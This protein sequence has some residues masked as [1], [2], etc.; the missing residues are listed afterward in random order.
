M[1]EAP[2]MTKD[3]IMRTALRDAETETLENLEAAGAMYDQLLSSYRPVR[4]DM[5]QDDA[6]GTP[7]PNGMLRWFGY[8][9]DQVE[10]PDDPVLKHD[11]TPQWIGTLPGFTCK[12]GISDARVTIETDGFRTNE[13]YSDEHEL[14]VIPERYRI[15]V[16]AHGFDRAQ[17]TVCPDWHEVQQTCRRIE[18]QLDESHD[19]RHQECQDEEG[20]LTSDACSFCERG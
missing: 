17:E 8:E 20:E 6:W 11:D 15:A 7:L 14:R 16:Q 13:D 5:V 3:E 1:Q 10:L 12:V 4:P 19:E 9:F 2:R 18:R